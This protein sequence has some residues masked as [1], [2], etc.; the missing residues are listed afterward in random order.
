MKENKE[1]QY[2]EK[3]WTRSHRPLHMKTLILQA[4]IKRVPKDILEPFVLEK[5]L[6]NNKL[7]EN[8][9]KYLEEYSCVDITENKRVGS[10]NRALKGLFF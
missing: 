5:S 4:L 8:I 10:R 9:Q 3:K 6:K 1:N 2:D 7:A